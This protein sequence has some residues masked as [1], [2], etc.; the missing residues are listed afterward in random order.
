MAGELTITVLA[1]KDLK[2]TDFFGKMDPFCVLKVG[3]ASE[4]TKTHVDG[5][6]NPIWNETFTFQIND[7]LE[8]TAELYDEDLLTAPDLLGTVS[9]DLAK[10]RSKLKDHIELPVIT[11]NEKH[12]GLLVVKLAFTPA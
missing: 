3:T 6:K 7:E 5:G 9:I 4:K 8:A 11:K 10:L 12:R 1:A 2:S